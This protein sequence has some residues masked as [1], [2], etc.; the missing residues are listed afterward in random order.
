MC[1]P[2]FCKFDGFV[3]HVLVLFSITFR[4]KMCY[5]DDSVR[6]CVTFYI[7]VDML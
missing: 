2:L 7:L 1:C 4:Y 3:G 6:V 5:H